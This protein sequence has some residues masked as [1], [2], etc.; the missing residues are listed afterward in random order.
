VSLNNIFYINLPTPNPMNDLF[1]VV[2]HHVNADLSHLSKFMDE[3]IA[4]INLKQVWKMKMLHRF[5][6]C[7]AN[8]ISLS[9]L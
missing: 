5:F 4:H 2:V 1:D 7:K 8:S 3:G 9:T 6:H